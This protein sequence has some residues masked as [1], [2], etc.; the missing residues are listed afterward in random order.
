MGYIA[1]RSETETGK[2]M[3]EGREHQ[4]VFPKGITMLGDKPPEPEGWFEVRTP[5]GVKAWTNNPGR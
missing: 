1:K 2:S 3:N 4:H 5:A